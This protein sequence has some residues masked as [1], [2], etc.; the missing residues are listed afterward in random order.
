MSGE[1]VDDG[2]ESPTLEALRRVVERFGPEVGEDPRRVQAGVNDL[3]GSD[4]RARRAEV[5]ALVIAAQESVPTALVGDTVERDALDRR[6][7][8]RGLSS[9][10]SSFALTAW[11]RA[12]GVD[13]S[14]EPVAG[15]PPL[16]T[17]PNTADA[18]DPGD[19]TSSVDPSARP[20]DEAT[21]HVGT[22]RVEVATADVAHARGA[23][24]LEVLDD[25]RPP[26]RRR[27]LLASIGAAAVLCVVALVAVVSLGGDDPDSNEMEVAGATQ[28]PAAVLPFDEET[29]DWG[30]KVE[31]RWELDD[32]TFE[33]ELVLSNDTKAPIAGRHVEIVPKS[34]AK[35]VDELAFD[36]EPDEVIDEDPVVA[37]D[38]RLGPGES[39]EITYRVEDLDGAAGLA[40]LKAWKKDRT[41]T[42]EEIMAEFE[43]AMKDVTVPPV[44]LLYPGANSTVGDAAITS[45]GTTEAD[46][47]IVINGTPAT[48]NP[49]GGFAAQISLTPGP[50][51]ISVSGTD[52]AGNENLVEINITYTPGFGKD[53]GG[54]TGDGGGGT[55]GGGNTG[56]GGGG[57]G[58]GGGGNTGDG[59]GG[60]TGD[61]GGTTGD[62]GGS[63]PPKDSDADGIPDSSDRCASQS[64]IPAHGGCPAPVLTVYGPSYVC[65]YPATHN[66]SVGWTGSLSASSYRWYADNGTNYTGGKSVSGLWFN[67]GRSFFTV[68]VTFDGVT[69]TQRT[70]VDA[71]DSC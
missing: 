19:A 34:L 36:P 2:A 53:S 51:K 27:V 11:S 64:G 29:T 33:S 5:D 25:V 4:A 15:L 3:L 37:W 41:A 44:N 32:G 6:L 9:A 13:R 48:V 22:P 69:Y 71:A 38:L 46:A 65:P 28:D 61:G 55:D 59:G 23:A 18:V 14:V 66:Y 45:F 47:K 8:D 35:T 39:T 17:L 1:M 7:R 58:D 26:R 63:T 49:D 57:T 67:P 70:Y 10:S 42:I 54:N 24:D 12:L 62:G 16:T 50:N 68:A 40:E 52:P 30:A 43:E 20:F 31:R 60:N 21:D 56:D